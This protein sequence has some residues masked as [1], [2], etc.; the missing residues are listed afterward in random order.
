VKLAVRRLSIAGSFEEQRF[1]QTLHLFKGTAG[2]NP[3]LT[4]YLSASPLPEP[5]GGGSSEQ[6]S[7]DPFPCIFAHYRINWHIYGTLD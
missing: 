5:I 2:W 6:S 1:T 7:N 3:A 4:V